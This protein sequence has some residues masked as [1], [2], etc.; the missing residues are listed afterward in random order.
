MGRHTLKEGKEMISGILNLGKS[1][2]YVVK[3]EFP[4]EKKPGN[5]PAVDAAWL[6]DEDHD[7]PLMIFEIE[8]K[9]TSSIA[10]NPVKVF[11]Q[12][13]ENF[14]KPLFFF[15]IVLKGTTDSSKIKNLQ[16]LFGLYNYRTYDLSKD[17]EVTRLIIDIISQHRRLYRKLDLEDLIKTFDHEIWKSADIEKILVSLEVRRFTA[18]YLRTYASFSF[19]DPDFIKHYLR[20][21][22]LHV[23][24]HPKKAI[25]QEYGTYWGD[26]WS[27]PI[28]YG[29]LIYSFPDKSAEYLQRFRNW[30]EKSTYL[31]MIG[32]H[33]GLSRDY[34]EFILGLSPPFWAFLAALMKKCSEAVEYIADQCQLILEELR[35]SAPRISFF[36][37][38]WLLHIA[39]AVSSNK[40]FE[41][42]RSLINHKA[43]ISEF[44][45]YNP[46]N[47]IPLEGENDTESDK[48]WN[49][50]LQERPIKVPDMDEFLSKLNN[51]LT[52]ANSKEEDVL[53]LAFEVL[54]DPGIHA[55]WAQRID[56][57]LHPN[58][59]LAA[60]R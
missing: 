44:F 41:F 42:A 31:T 23:H 60:D 39:A 36:T 21:L 56:R 5:P 20:F 26:M 29:I 55:S 43:G 15:H 33:F 59:A 34:D 2:G 48:K 47:S 52:K 24:S 49:K 37:A 50:E 40:H 3:E 22:E 53:C 35:E 54:L 27:D 10:N 11:G 14:E 19:H 9:V 46:P 13:N 57:C 38:L 45:L 32:P 12:P 4:L 8:S 18:N 6:S 16:T 1:L 58:K 51:A 28:H 30:Q 25:P 17:D 7:F